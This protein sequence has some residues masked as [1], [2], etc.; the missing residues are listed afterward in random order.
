MSEPA[1]Q[2]ATIQQDTASLSTPGKRR[3]SALDR[4]FPSGKILGGFVV[5]I[6]LLQVIAGWKVVNLGQEK[7]EVTRL[8]SLLEKD[9]KDH[10]Y[11]TRELPGLKK[12]WGETETNVRHLRGEVAALEKQRASLKGELPEIEKRAQELRATSEQ[13]EATKSALEKTIGA[14]KG[15]I[16]EKTSELSQL[17]QVQGVVAVCEDFLRRQGSGLWCHGD[18]GYDATSSKTGRKGASWR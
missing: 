8:R 16:P 11:L 14:L 10:E 17:T 1:N 9:I 4:G 7:A 3:S 6:I 2:T 12:E 5:L 18:I 13:Y 15:E